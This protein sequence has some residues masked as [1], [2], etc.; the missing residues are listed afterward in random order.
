MTHQGELHCEGLATDVTFVRA[1]SSVDTAMALEVIGLCEGLTT[2]V[3]LKWAYTS[4]DQLMP[5]KGVPVCEGLSTCVALEGLLL[6]VCPHMR[7]Q[8]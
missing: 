2:F 8:W 1:Q 4:V 5:G 3:A 7:Q 6:A